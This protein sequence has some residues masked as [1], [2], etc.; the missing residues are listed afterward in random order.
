MLPNQRLCPRERELREAL[1]QVGRT[2]CAARPS[3]AAAVARAIF[4]VNES[5]LL[6]ASAAG[7]GERGCE[8]YGIES[9]G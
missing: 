1:E 6:T 7:R 5:V 2:A 4:A 8:G 9:P 3:D